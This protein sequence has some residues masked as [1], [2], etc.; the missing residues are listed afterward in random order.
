MSKCFKCLFNRCRKSIVSNV[1]FCH[2]PN[3][4][5]IKPGFFFCIVLIE[6]CNMISTSRRPVMGYVAK[7]IGK[8]FL[9]LF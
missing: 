3:S 8:S 6:R 4:I 2:Q 9:Q 5:C 7:F 1:R